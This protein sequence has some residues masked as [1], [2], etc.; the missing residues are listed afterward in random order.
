LS[1]QDRDRT[2]LAVEL[3]R[4]GGTMLAEPC[5]KCGGVRVSFHGGVYCTGHD[6]LSAVTA[7]ETIPMDTV[8]AGVRDVLLSKLNEGAALLRQEKDIAK[9]EQ[10][11]SLL[12][13]YYD[14][15]EKVSRKQQSA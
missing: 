14:L 2:K 13:V 15:L 4:K 10:M 7:A 5:T 8:M 11:A 6:D 9:Q 12:T 3:V 1:R